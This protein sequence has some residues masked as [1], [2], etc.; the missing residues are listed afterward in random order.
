MTS[1]VALTWSNRRPTIPS[2]SLD[3]FCHCQGTTRGA[4]GQAH[5]WAV[6]ANPIWSL[7]P[8]PGCGERL[9]GPAP[10]TSS[11]ASRDPS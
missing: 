10:S 11:E 6:F 2:V 8:E 1:S 3:E 4:A 7:S 5:R 9:A